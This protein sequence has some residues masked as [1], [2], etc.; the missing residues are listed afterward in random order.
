MRHGRTRGLS[1]VQGLED[2]VCESAYRLSFTCLFGR[3]PVNE[4]YTEVAELHCIN[5]AFHL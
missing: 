5:L 2:M 1:L 3:V 4:G